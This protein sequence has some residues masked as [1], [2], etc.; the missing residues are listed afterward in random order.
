LSSRRRSG[1]WPGALLTHDHG[2]ALHQA[3][4]DWCERIDRALA[5]TDAAAPAAVTLRSVL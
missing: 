2:R 3:A 1:A 4:V 5:Q